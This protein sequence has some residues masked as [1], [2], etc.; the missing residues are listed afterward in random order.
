MRES[1]QLHLFSRIYCW[2][3]LR[4]P[5]LNYRLPKM[6]KNLMRLMLL[7]VLKREEIV[8]R[9]GSAMSAMKTADF[10]GGFVPICSE[11]MME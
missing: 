2:G 4:S 9:F 11:I 1:S 6:Y 7:V 3:K 5:I 8:I 10:C